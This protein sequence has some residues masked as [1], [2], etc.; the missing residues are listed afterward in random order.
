MDPLVALVPGDLPFL[1]VLIVW[2]FRGEHDDRQDGWWFFAVSGGGRQAGDFLASRQQRHPQPRLSHPPVTEQHA[3][4]RPRRA[5]RGTCISWAR[6]RAE[7]LRPFLCA[8]DA[9]TV[10]HTRVPL[11]NTSSSVFVLFSRMLS[12]PNRDRLSLPRA[13]PHHTVILWRKL[14]FFAHAMAKGTTAAAAYVSLQD[15]MRMHLYIRLQQ[16]LAIHPWSKALQKCSLPPSKVSPSKQPSLQCFHHQLPQHSFH[17]TL[18]VITPRHTHRDVLSH[19]RNRL[20]QS[21]RFALQLCVRIDPVYNQQ[22]HNHPYDSRQY[23]NHNYLGAGC[24]H[25]PGSHRRYRCS[26]LDDLPDPSRQETIARHASQR[27]WCVNFSFDCRL[28]YAGLI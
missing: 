20:H 15:A 1:T 23:P 16:E 3:H 24:E 17:H 22:Q 26:G 9:V 12:L 19:Q 7:I 27:E 14:Y 11:C 10:R 28:S 8:S 5:V 2:G 6:I 25:R 21:K 18:A 4:L 13:C